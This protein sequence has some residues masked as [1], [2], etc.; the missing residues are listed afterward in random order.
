MKFRRAV[1][2]DVP[3]VRRIHRAAIREV[4]SS[5]YSIEVIDAWLASN[6]DERYLT[7]I[8][9]QSFWI[10]EDR[11]Q[12]LGFGGV[13]IPNCLLESLFLDPAARGR[14][15]AGRFLVHLEQVAL[16][17][18][19]RKLRLKSSITARG[20]YA[21]H[22]YRTEQGD[23]SIRLESGVIL[24]GIPMVKTLQPDPCPRPSDDGELCLGPLP[25]GMTIVDRPAGADVRRLLEEA[26]LPTSDL[27]PEKLG[28]FFACERVGRLEAIA[29]LELYGAD[30]LLRSV[31]VS[32]QCRSQGLGAAL[33]AHAEGAARVGGVARLFLLTNTAERFFSRL[34]YERV[35]RAAAPPAIRNTSEFSALCP[36]SAVLMVKQLRDPAR[37]PPAT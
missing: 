9:E 22:G 36:T 15:L 28:N 31:V 33:V 18:G 32:P 16:A 1:T 35:A 6:R 10:A 4:C 11:G 29:G 23:G 19:V 34:G 24:T 8:R 2:S 5:D 27:T 20:F 3:V 25:V 17:A 26:D 13:D 37:D 7:A 21:K 14:G 30:G 12:P